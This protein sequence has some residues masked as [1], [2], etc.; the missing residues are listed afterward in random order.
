MDNIKIEEKNFDKFIYKGS[1]ALESYYDD[2]N[3]N[4]EVFDEFN[5]KLKAYRKLSEKNKADK[6]FIVDALI[7]A[8]NQMGIENFVIYEDGDVEYNYNKNKKV[9][10]FY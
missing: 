6:E 8:I 1:L 10:F 5:Y 9:G 7:L 2:N 4:K 3:S